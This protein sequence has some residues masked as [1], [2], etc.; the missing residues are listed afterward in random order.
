MCEAEGGDCGK[1]ENKVGP[2]KGEAA[3]AQPQQTVAIWGFGSCVARFSGVSREVRK[4]DFYVRSSIFQHQEL[5]C[6]VC[7]VF[8]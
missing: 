8:L 7:L 3:P 5:F 1:L 4:L 6:L 2:V